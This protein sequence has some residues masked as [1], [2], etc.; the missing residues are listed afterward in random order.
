MTQVGHTEY[1]SMRRE[2]T[3]TMRPRPGL[4]LFSIVS[5]YQKLLP[6]CLWLQVIPDAL[7]E[8]QRPKRVPESSTMVKYSV[9]QGNSGV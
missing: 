5:Y 8:G 4:L 7:Q 1:Q 3:N 6:D 2:E 9:I